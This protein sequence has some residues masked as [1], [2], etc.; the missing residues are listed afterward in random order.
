M[1]QII[2]IIIESRL[3]FCLLPPLRRGGEILHADVHRVCAGHGL[4]LMAI[5]VIVEKKMKIL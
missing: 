2:Y 3:S 5:V 4:G 1:G